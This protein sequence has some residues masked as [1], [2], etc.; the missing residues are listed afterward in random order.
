MIE[1]RYY[2]DISHIHLI[3]LQKGTQKA[4]YG[5]ILTFENFEK[6]LHIKNLKLALKVSMIVLTPTVFPKFDI[7]RCP[8]QL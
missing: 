1:P 6:N 2:S 7:G 8:L 5:L 4:R 3:I